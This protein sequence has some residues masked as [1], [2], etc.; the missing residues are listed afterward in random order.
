MDEHGENWG[1][2]RKGAGRPRAAYVRLKD[3]TVPREVWDALEQ[4][5][6]RKGVTPADLAAEVLEDYATAPLF[7]KI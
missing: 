7:A 5:A 3:V 1:G 6:Q 2:K 4:Q